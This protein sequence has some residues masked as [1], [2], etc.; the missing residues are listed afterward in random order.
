MALVFF[1]TSTVLAGGNGIGIR[2]SNRELDPLWGASVRFLLGALVLGAI[3][4]VMRLELPTRRELRL[5]SL[6]G[7][8][9]FGLAYA[10]LYLGMVHVHAG[11]AQTLLALVPLLTLLLAAAEGQERFRMR[12][13]LGALLALCGIA[14]IAGAPLDAE[15]PILALLAVVATA[16]L[17]AQGTVLI[18]HL[19]MHP[20]TINAVGMA[21][22]GAMLLLASVVA[23][24]SFGVP[25]RAET[26]A[27]LAYLVF[28][29]SAAVFVLFAAVLRRWEASRVAYGFVLTPFITIALSAWLDDEPL[30]LGLIAGGVLVLGG[31]YFGALRGGVPDAEPVRA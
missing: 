9:G 28:A 2:F 16:I 23:G 12:S 6:F 4:V 11:L 15:I 27:A 29:G 14:V 10:L 31:V 26:W 21:V 19:Q 8:I 13:L 17:F 22:G 1:A 20:V 7:A 5:A 24:E 3:V 30:G 25:E 18:R